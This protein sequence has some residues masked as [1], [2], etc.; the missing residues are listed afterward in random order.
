MNAELIAVG[1]ELLLGEISNTDGQYISQKLASLGINVFYHT[2]VGDNP[3]RLEKVLED[4]SRRSDLVITTGGLGPTYDDL[5]KELICKVFGRKLVLHQESL[6]RIEAFFTDR[7]RPMTENNVKQ[8]YLPEG[9]T[10]FANDWGTAPGCAFETENC[11]VAMLPGPPRECRPMTDLRLVPYLAK[12]GDGVIYSDSVRIC[13]MGES[14]V[15]DILRPIMENAVNPTVAPYCKLGEVELRVTAKAESEAA[16]KA[17]TAPVVEKIK[18]TLG[19]VVYG[20]NIDNLEQ[21]VVAELKEKGLTLATA[22]SC[23]GGLVSKRIT[24][25]S[26]SSEVFLGGVVSYANSVKEGVLGVKSETLASVGAVSAETAGEMA[27]GVCA[28]T[29]ADVG[30]SLTGIAGPGGGSE[31][32]PVGLV[33]MGLCRGENVSVT[34]LRIGSRGRTRDDIR[35]QAATTALKAVLDEIRK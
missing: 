23:T 20:V 26:G 34:E 7:G 3:A 11:T 6:A 24:D 13:G 5:T 35:S 1:T 2:V 18:E 28:L 15:E 32:K 29:G 33:Y 16:A 17:L 31:E 30:V 25:V 12:K 4:A 22:E 27:K 21:A 14:A 19:D 8:A 10:V 9:C